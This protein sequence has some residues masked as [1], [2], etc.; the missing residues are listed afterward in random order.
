MALGLSNNYEQRVLN[1]IFKQTAPPTPASELWYGLN[2]STPGDTGAS[3]IAATGGY[4]RAGLFPDATSVSHVRYNAIT[5]SGDNSRIT[6][7]LDITFPQATTGG[8]NAGSAIGWWTVWDGL[9][10]ANVIAAGTITGTVVVL[11]SNTL[12]FAGSVSG[13]AL[14]FD[15]D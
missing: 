12:K 2:G 14:S 13:G 3:E 9:T 5:T 7:L 10:A 8:F 15:V 4:A 6:N 1:Y 11:E